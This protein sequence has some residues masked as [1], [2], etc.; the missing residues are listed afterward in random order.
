MKTDSNTM[1][2]ILKLHEQ[3]VKEIE[4]SGM[5]RL[6]ANIYKINSQNFVRWISDD[7]VPG[8]KVK[9]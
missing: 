2:E 6:S 1:S 7:F 8:G 5:K 9:K 4:I 3:Y